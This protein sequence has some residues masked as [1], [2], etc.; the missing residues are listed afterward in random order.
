MPAF[1]DAIPTDFLESGE[2]T[3]VN[4]D[5]FPIAIANAGGVYCA[6]QNMCPHQ[7]TPLGGRPVVDGVITCSQHASKYDVRTGECVKPADGDGF[8]QGLM[9]FEVEV[10]DEV[11]RVKV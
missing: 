5:G 6:F 2:S 8:S 7:A 10:V 4:V 3:T 1:Y 11:V 9:T